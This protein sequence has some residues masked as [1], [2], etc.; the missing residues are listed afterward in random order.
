GVGR[1]VHWDGCRGSRPGGGRAPRRSRGR[2]GA[3][4][5]ETRERETGCSA[6]V[7]IES[8]PGDHLLHRLLPAGVDWGASI[9]PVPMGDN[10]E[11]AGFDARLAHVDVGSERVALWQVDDL[12]RHVDRRALL[13]DDDAPDPPYWPP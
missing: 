11:I 5:A 4:N 3:G 1:P 6:P 2:S 9:A 10:R 13:A 7:A 8:P 12:E